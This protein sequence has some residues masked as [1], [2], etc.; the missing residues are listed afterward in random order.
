MLGNAKSGNWSRLTQ[1]VLGLAHI[2]GLLVFIQALGSK[3]GKE[4]DIQISD[5]N[6]S[7]A[8]VYTTYTA[9]PILSPFI[10]MY[11]IS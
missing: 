3:R 5:F 9:S 1:D 4:V 10:V 11:K 7:A 6:V 2:I 8:Q